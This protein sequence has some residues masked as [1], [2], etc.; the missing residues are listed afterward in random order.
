MA[1]TTNYNWET[2]DDTDLVKDG[3]AA[4]RTLGSSV[5]TTTKAL[6]PSTTLG[7][8]EYR[9]STANTNT[10]LPIGTTGQ[11][12]SVVGGVPSWV[13][14][15]V[16]DITEV[17]AGT[18]ISVASGTGPIPIITNTVATAIDAKGDLIGG[19]GADTFARL[20]VGANDTVLTA[21]SSAA[22]GLKWATPASSG[23]M[24]LLSTT[25]LSGS[26]TTLT[27]FSSSYKSFV[28]YVRN[29]RPATN[30]ATLQMRFNGDANTRYTNV[31]ASTATVSQ[32]QNATSINVMAANND[33]YD[34][35][36]A[37]IEIPDYANSA[38][39]KIARINS[40]ADQDTTFNQMFNV[41]FYKVSSYAITSIALFPSSG[42]FTSGSALLYGV[43]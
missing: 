25:T 28:I 39:Y 27:S 38:T 5:D 18:G 23:G 19:T 43:N 41:G 6:N 16:G 24:T 10:R 17:Q 15:D 1:N 42:N 36:L 34:K 26:S 12:L 32:S 30:N 22:T 8:I 33:L 21:D 9:S 37:V 13:A 7:D 4:I 31:L 11:I 40:Y 2:P 20:A 14:N 35:G 3:A 29:F